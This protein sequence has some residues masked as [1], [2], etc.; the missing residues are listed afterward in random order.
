MP[1]KELELILKLIQ[2][3]GEGKIVWK[4]SPT[5]FT[6]SVGEKLEVNLVRQSAFLGTT[7]LG[8]SLF[9]VRDR[10]GNE[11]VKVL[12]RPLAPMAMAESPDLVSTVDKL[13]EEVMRAQQ[14]DIEKA[15]GIVDSI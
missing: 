5:A 10:K 14:R 9:T 4:F 1:R 8:W 12:H 15:I 11:L 6:S 3:T 7:G 2:K 13:Y